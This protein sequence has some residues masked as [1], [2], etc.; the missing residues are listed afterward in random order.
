MA[1]S[2]PVGQ[3]PWETSGQGAPPK[4]FPV[5]QAPWETGSSHENDPGIAQTILEHGANGVAMG[6]LPQ[7]QAATEKPMFAAMNALTGRSGD[8]AVKPDDYLKARDANIS[9]L[10]AEQTANPKTAL[11]SQIGGGILGAAATPL[12]EIEA[13]KGAGILANTAKGAMYGAGYGAAQNPGDVAGQLNPIQATDRLKNAGTGLLTGMA[14]GAGTASTGKIL[15][16]IGNASQ[17]LSETAEEQALHA[18]GAMLKDL[19]ALDGQDRTSDIGRYA[20][21]TGLVRAG[22][23]VGDIAS[24]AE[25]KNADA[26]KALD[27]IYGKAVDAVKSNPTNAQR[28]NAFITPNEKSA[29]QMG[30]ETQLMNEVPKKFTQRLKGDVSS[31]DS[32]PVTQESMRPDAPGQAVFPSNEEDHTMSLPV[33]ADEK[34][35]Y[36]TGFNPVRDKAA[37]IAAADKS[38]G[39]Q[40]GKGR[41]LNALGDYLDQLGKDHGDNTLDPK[42]SNNI[43]SSID[44]TINYSRNPFQPD[45]V[46]EQ[47]F[48]SARGFVAN[49]IDEH[50]QA[51][52]EATGSPDLADQ[53]KDAN[54]DYGFSKTI[55]DMARDKDLRLNQNRIFGLTDTM[56]GV[57]GA[58]AGAGAGAA[59]GGDTKHTLEG[60][61]AGLGLGLLNKYGRK[62]GPAA[63]A[64]GADLASYPAV[65]GK[66]LGYLGN[67]GVVDAATRGLIEA[68]LLNKKKDARP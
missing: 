66:P 36:N 2:Y 56:A 26:G 40:E 44:K 50:M 54:R 31:M 46:K 67:P 8:D 11:L 45:P 43:K 6:Y 25:S 14:T 27:E 1:T 15:R 4:S 65:A 49:A 13:L 9:R 17:S 21:D 62:Y 58:V 59:L 7:L 35:F 19:R 38:I 20:L 3:A 42:T 41:A 68:R 52:G 24:K 57:G 37:I 39:N 64:Q 29:V 28:G 12:P 48:R 47:A 60:M 10:D 5:G 18:S 53:L 22:D 23:T 51:I 33:G 63:I 34:N 30:N 61:G 55:A 32:V 16:G